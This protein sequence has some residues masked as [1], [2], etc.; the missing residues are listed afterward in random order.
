MLLGWAEVAEVAWA[1]ADGGDGYVV[2]STD[3]LL[4]Y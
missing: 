1:V 2:W 4:P 3:H